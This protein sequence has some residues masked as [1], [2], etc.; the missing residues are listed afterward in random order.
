LTKRI[1]AEKGEIMTGVHASLDARSVASL[2]G[3]WRDAGVDS[4]V[5]D[6]AQPWIG[7]AAVTAKPVVETPA[8]LPATLSSFVDWLQNS[9]D[10]PGAGPPQRRIAPSGMAGAPIMVMVDMPESSDHAAQQLLSG[11][12][13]VLFDRMLAAIGL[14]RSQIYLAPLCPGR[15]ATGQISEEYFKRLAEIARHHIGLA[16]PKRVWLLGQTTSRVLL[17]VDSVAARGKL[18]FINH[19]G[20]NVEVVASLHPRLLL[21]NPGRKAGTWADMQL[22]AKGILGEF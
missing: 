2:I 8:I 5:E 18:H 4:F 3:W 22:L 9:P 7:R 10:I 21:Q 20:G 17:G 14:D 11:D 19:D 1:S 15:P 16:K 6:E 13:G 12:A